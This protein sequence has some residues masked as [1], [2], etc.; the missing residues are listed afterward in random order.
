MAKYHGNAAV[1]VT[2]RFNE[3]DPLVADSEE[4]V[5]QSL[6]DRINILLDH[7]LHDRLYLRREV[8]EYGADT[9]T[10]EFAVVANKI[11][12]EK[13]PNRFDCEHAETAVD[14][15]D[16]EQ[17]SQSYRVTLDYTYESS[18]SATVFIEEA[19]DEDDAKSQAEQ[20][21]E[22]VY[23]FDDLENTAE[24]VEE[25]EWSVTDTTVRRCE[26]SDY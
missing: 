3:S 24:S 5:R 9:H 14:L 23:S 6:E 20:L 17:M 1:T 16:L 19:D 10:G 15:S 4:M 7:W 18:G 12:Y 8:P 13:Y 11:E 26:A 2:L 22:D 21:L 25:Y